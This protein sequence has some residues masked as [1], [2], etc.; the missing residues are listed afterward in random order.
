MLL[1]L[2]FDSKARKKPARI[3]AIVVDIAV[4]GQTS[5]VEYAHQWLKDRGP[6]WGYY[7]NSSTSANEKKREVHDNPG[8]SVQAKG[9][10][11]Q[12]CR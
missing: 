6:E 5:H 10:H 1:E 2:L 7:S 12:Q 9:R 3:G 8:A 11:R 4:Q